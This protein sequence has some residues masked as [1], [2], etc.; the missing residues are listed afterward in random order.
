MYQLENMCLVP[1]QQVNGA[2]FES[3]S[4]TFL[5]K[6]LTKPYQQRQ[7]ADGNKCAKR[8]FILQEE[9]NTRHQQKRSRV[10][11]TAPKDL[12]Q[13]LSSVEKRMKK[14]H[15]KRKVKT[16]TQLG[17]DSHPNV[18]TSCIIHL[19]YFP[20]KSSIRCSWAKHLKPFSPREASFSAP[21]EQKFAS[22]LTL[23]LKFDLKSS[24]NCCYFNCMYRGGLI[25]QS[26][27]NSCT[28]WD[29]MNGVTKLLVL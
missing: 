12:I 22:F 21:S 14:K 27:L 13:L 3:M 9:F 1:Q 8:H 4:C 10:G 25:I 24:T 7:T 18:Q 15:P 19:H 29:S 5:G 16:H 2:V 11:S 28:H 17:S 23:T 6:V 26:F 20:R